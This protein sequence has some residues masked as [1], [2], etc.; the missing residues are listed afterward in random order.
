MNESSHACEWVIARHSFVYLCTYIYIYI[1]IHIHKKVSCHHPFTRVRRLIHMYDMTPYVCMRHTTRVHCLWWQ[2]ARR[3][4]VAKAT[5]P[6][7]SVLCDRTHL[8]MFHDLFTCVTWLIQMCDMTHWYV[9]H[10]SFIHVKWV[11]HICDMTYS[12]MWRDSFI[13][14]TW[15][16]QMCDMTH[17]DV[18]HDSLT[19]VTC[20]LDTCDMTQSHVWHDSFTYVDSSLHFGSR[21]YT[22][23]IWSKKFF[24]LVFASAVLLERWPQPGSTA[25]RRFAASRSRVHYFWPIISCTKQRIQWNAFQTGSRRGK[26]AASARACLGKANTER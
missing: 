19:C 24:R 10:D 16:I 8:N 13:C 9:W 4:T 25:G 1:Y 7:G 12:Y 23:F 22:R 6:R 14:V 20:F 21:T 3:R 17:S 11:I 2:L 18:W 15:L 5:A 26:P